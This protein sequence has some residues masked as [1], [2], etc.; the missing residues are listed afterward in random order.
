[1]LWQHLFW[2]FGHPEVYIAIVPGMGIV[3]HVLI[4]NMRKPMLSHR[5]LIYSMGALAVLS[6]MV[7]GHH[8]FVSG[9]NPFSSLAFSFPTLVITIPVDNRRADLDFQ[10]VRFE[11]A[12]QLGF[13]VC[14]G[15][16][17]DVR[18]PAA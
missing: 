15:L 16:H 13:S 6:Y 10:P 3:S 1:L 5:V 18:Q 11:A 8:M 12:H 14:A 7:Y 17:F 4:T 2:F 9:M